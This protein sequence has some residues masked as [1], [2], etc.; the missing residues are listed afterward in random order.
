MGP[1]AGL[2]GCGKS[3]PH[4]DSIPGPSSP[5]EV[6]I[7]TELSRPTILYGGAQYLCV[8]LQMSAPLCCTLQQGW[9]VIEIRWAC[10]QFRQTVPA[11]EL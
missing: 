7:P 9:T 10:H 3:R 8:L 11:R 2:D 6:A 1:R 4:R 5:Q